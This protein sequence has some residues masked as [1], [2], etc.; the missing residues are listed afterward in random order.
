MSEDIKKECNINGENNN[1]NNEDKVKALLQKNKAAALGLA[2]F[3]TLGTTLTGC[4]G[5]DDYYNGTDFGPTSTDDAYQSGTSHSG[6]YHGHSSGSGWRV[7][8]GSSGGSG[9]S[10]GRSGSGGSVGG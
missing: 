4:G 7:G 9:Y 1:K 6:S 10:S 2:V 8:G 5:N 3:L